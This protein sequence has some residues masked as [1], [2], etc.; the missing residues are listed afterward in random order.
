MSANAI[1]DLSFDHPLRQQLKVFG[2][3]PVVDAPSCRIPAVASGSIMLHMQKS[4]TLD[5]H[6]IFSP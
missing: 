2:L 6:D 1:T 3:T 4:R 5:L